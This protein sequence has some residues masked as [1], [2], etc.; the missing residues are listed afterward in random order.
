MPA[1]VAQLLVAETFIGSPGVLGA[2][3][4]PDFAALVKEHAPPGGGNAQLAVLMREEGVFDAMARAVERVH[5]RLTGAAP[6]LGVGPR[7]L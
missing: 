3:P 5:G 7:L 1:A 6:T 4:E 2:A